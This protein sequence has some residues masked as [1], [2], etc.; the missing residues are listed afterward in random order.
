[1]NAIHANHSRQPRNEDLSEVWHDL[2][3]RANMFVQLACGAAGVAGVVAFSMVPTRWVCV[4][5][6]LIL[7]GCFA[8]ASVLLRAE[9]FTLEPTRIAMIRAAQLVVNVVAIIVAIAVALSA[10]ALLFG[11]SVGIM[12]V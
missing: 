12:R 6:A 8:L 2:A 1:M 10:L 4:P 5:L 11:G 7:L 3:L 9:L